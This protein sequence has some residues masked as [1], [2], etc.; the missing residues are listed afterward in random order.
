MALIALEIVDESSTCQSLL[1]RFHAPTSMSMVVDRERMQRRSGS[2]RLSKGEWLKSRSMPKMRRDSKE[3]SSVG[4]DKADS[5]PLTPSK[6]VEEEE[7]MTSEAVSTPGSSEISVTPPSRSRRFS[8]ASQQVKE[9][10]RRWLM[11]Q[12]T[13]VDSS[14][15]RSQLQQAHDELR[16]QRRSTITGSR[17]ER[18]LFSAST[19]SATT[20]ADDG[21][22][23]LHLRL[24][25]DLEDERRK[26]REAEAEAEAAR[27]PAAQRAAADG[28][29]S[30]E[31]N[32]LRKTVQELQ[33]SQA[34]M[35]KMLREKVESSERRSEEAAR[36]AER[37]IHTLSEEAAK[38]A[39]RR[40]EEA[41]KAAGEAAEKQVAEAAKKLVAEKRVAQAAEKE[42]AK[43]LAEKLEAAEKLLV[44]QEEFEAKKKEAEA[45]K[46]A[47][48]E[49]KIRQLEERISRLS[50]DVQHRP[51]QA[52]PAESALVVAADSPFVYGSALA[53]AIASA[54]AAISAVVVISH[55]VAVAIITL[56]QMGHA[57][58]MRITGVVEL[59]R[60]GRS[61]L[62]AAAQSLQLPSPPQ[63]MAPL[64]RSW[65]KLRGPRPPPIVASASNPPP[66]KPMPPPP[67][68]RKRNTPP[69]SPS[70]TKGLSSTN[71]STPKLMEEIRN[72][73]K[74]K[75]SRSVPGTPNSMSR[76]G[77]FE[78]VGVSPSP[79][80]LKELL[81]VAITQRRGSFNEGSDDED[82]E[83]DAWGVKKR[84]PIVDP[85]PAQSQADEK[86][87]TLSPL[88]PK[89]P[90]RTRRS[91]D[92]PLDSRVTRHT[93]P[94]KR[95][96]GALVQKYAQQVAADAAKAEAE[97]AKAETRQQQPEQQTNVHELD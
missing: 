77:S 44:K 48:S 72:A 23:A 2:G 30:D 76:R 10:Q 26:R 35:V 19:K 18:G 34:D 82:D 3:G 73:P 14:D 42:A 4:A 83:D 92:E 80:K 54:V 65:S 88:P 87:D 90:S 12:E 20:G 13:V 7:G 84:L 32:T 91:H 63:L 56:V 24:L 61:R 41:A 40:G 5:P 33:S 31:V 66:L 38:E 64:R 85:T 39:E 79:Q 21:I 25:S 55:T 53:A 75:A 27:S 68:P 95:F 50:H 47:E 60:M 97:E 70:S 93:W 8:P 74:L 71:P 45:A 9:Q 36:A 78:D 57:H 16:R 69:I 94:S 37:R 49:A 17:S 43:K 89:P 96:D 15:L 59:L 1:S 67:P 11:E 46:Q 51:P 22:E 62:G 6:G 86:L 28:V 29:S 81:S 52:A 58:T